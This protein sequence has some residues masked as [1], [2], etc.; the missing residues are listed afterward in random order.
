MYRIKEYLVKKKISCANIN[1][2]ISYTIIT[3][4][5]IFYRVEIIY[6]LD[7]NNIGVMTYLNG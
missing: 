4:K 6:Y 5:S 1:N 3:F 7:L 2:L